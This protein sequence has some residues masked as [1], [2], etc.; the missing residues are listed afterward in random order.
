MNRLA[1][2]AAGVLAVVL[3]LS[4]GAREAVAAISFNVTYLDVTG[5]TGAGFDDPT[6]GAA[7]RST[8]A[9]VFNYINTVVN[10]NGSVDVRVNASE[11]DHSGPLA[12]GAPWFDNSSNGFFNGL[13][14]DHAT[15]GDDLWPLAPDASV[16]FDF[17]Y[18]W[19]SETDAPTGS[20]VDLFSVSLHEMTHTLG[21][22]SLL[23]QNGTSA[24]S[25]GDPGVFS[26]YDSL[27]E[28]GD[29]T[30]LFGP[31]GDYLGTPADLTSND[32]FFGGTHAK[33]ANGGNAVKV[34]A[35]S[36]YKSGSSIGH[37]Q[38]GVGEVMQPSIGPGVTR[39]QY[40]APEIGI[41]ADLGWTTA[42]PEPG[43]LAIWSLLVLVG[44][45]FGR[46]RRK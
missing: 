42:V 7:R 3:A 23:T 32:V 36:P 17:G 21:F 22:L 14:F 39:R 26:V 4:V 12:S 41:L 27:L 19:N 44:V 38:L 24:V 46:R 34:Y 5:S 25:G 1:T 8:F 15:T 45:R 18:N 13:A 16:T 29:G 10:E 20:E 11:T 6:L 35:P 28:R 31:N 2:A 43:S 40:T 30:A 33:A 37:L 9:S